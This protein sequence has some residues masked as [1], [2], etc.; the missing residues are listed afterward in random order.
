MYST[1]TL[2][3][4]HHNIVCMFQTSP[5]EFSTC[6]YWNISESII[7][8]KKSTCSHFL[9][10][11][12]VNYWALPSICKPRE[13]LAMLPIHV[14]KVDY[15]AA[16]RHT[17][18]ATGLMTVIQCSFPCKFQTGIRE[19]WRLHL[20]GKGLALARNIV[21]SAV[22]YFNVASHLF[23]KLLRRKKGLVNCQR[24][25]ATEGHEN[26]QYVDKHCYSVTITQK[27]S[28]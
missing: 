23:A 12:Q 9:E 3:C 15:G 26:W 20:R 19:G 17:S 2:Y 10:L 11:F 6:I 22:L 28:Q 5:Q 21:V 1:K 25:I 24:V 13:W 8:N 27:I 18:T 4:I 16:E 7:T 14:C